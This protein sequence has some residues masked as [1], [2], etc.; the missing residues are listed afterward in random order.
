MIAKVEQKTIG[1]PTHHA[2][3]IY[4]GAVTEKER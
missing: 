1:A 3:I 2:H 4:K